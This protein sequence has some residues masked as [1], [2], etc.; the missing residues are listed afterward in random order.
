MYVVKTNAFSLTDI[1]ALEK[2]TGV[3]CRMRLLLHARYLLDVNDAA[4]L[5]ESDEYAK[6]R[7]QQA[8]SADSATVV[9][10]EDAVKRPIRVKF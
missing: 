8:L 3:S 5:R 10:L 9:F 1:D 2:K 7:A 6:W 4:K